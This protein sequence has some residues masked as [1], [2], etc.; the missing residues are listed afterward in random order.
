MTTRRSLLLL[1]GSLSFLGCASTPKEIVELSYAMGNDLA[2]VHKSYRNLV[3]ERFEGFRA[4]RLD[5]LNKWRST[6]LRDWTERGRLGDIAAS[7]A[8]WSMSERKF[9]PPTA[10]KE[11]EERIQS[12]QVWARTA[13]SDIEKKKK[14]LMDPLDK[15]EQSMLTM[16]DDAFNRLYRGNA[17]ITAH[18]NSLRKVQEVQ[19]EALK[20]LRVKDFRDTIDAKF[21]EVSERARKGLEDIEKAGMK[22]ERVVEELQK[23]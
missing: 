5:Y 6:Y 2:A 15:D 1:V 8:T 22:A 9:T 12:L 16:I 20:A 3:H 23:P 13:I 10:G 19:D 21:L 11:G 18:L 14:T 17:A 4:E 7:K